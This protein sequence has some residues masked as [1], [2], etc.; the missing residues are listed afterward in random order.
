[1][2]EGAHQKGNI[3]SDSGEKIIGFGFEIT[4]GNLR[5]SE[6]GAA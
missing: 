6:W 3:F 2:Q 5:K 4:K 1:M